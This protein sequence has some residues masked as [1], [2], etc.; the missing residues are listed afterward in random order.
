MTWPRWLVTVCAA[1][2]DPTPRLRTAAA[3][4]M[5]FFMMVSCSMMESRWRGLGRLRLAAGRITAVSR[6]VDD[7][8][9]MV[10]HGLGGEGRSD[11]KAQDRG[12]CKNELFHDG[13][14]FDDGKPMAVAGSAAI[15][16]RP[17]HCCKPGRR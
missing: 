7:L 17:H 4:R 5:N 1:K 14:L 16:R 10:G 6:A 9:E 11:A 12:C 15:R 8:A 3:A 13:L 2:A